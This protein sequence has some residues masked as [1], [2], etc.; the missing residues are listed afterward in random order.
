[1]HQHWDV[2]KA[3]ATALLAKDCEP[4]KPLKSGCKWSNE[5]TAK[6]V[7]ADEVVSLLERHGIPATC[8]T[9]C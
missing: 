8:G 3:L 6:Y 1:V 9:D 5:A 2:V 4:L 7:T